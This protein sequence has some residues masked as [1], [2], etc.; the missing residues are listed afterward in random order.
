[1]YLKVLV[2]ALHR[3]SQT[4]REAEAESHGSLDVLLLV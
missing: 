2:L 1:M 3:Q 4:H